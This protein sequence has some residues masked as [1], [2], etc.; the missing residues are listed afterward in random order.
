MY[1]PTRLDGTLVDGFIALPE[2][3]HFSKGNKCCSYIVKAAH[4]A[5]NS[6][7]MSTDNLIIIVIESIH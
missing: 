1:Q 5:S 6:V 3:K 2:G 7:L 4:S